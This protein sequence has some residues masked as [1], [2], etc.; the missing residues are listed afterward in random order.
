MKNI[1]IV[2]VPRTGKTTLTKLIKQE[3]PQ[4][5]LISFEAIRNGFIKSQPELNMGSKKS[6]SSEFYLWIC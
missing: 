2:G 3:I 5:N 4:V 6:N 1:Y